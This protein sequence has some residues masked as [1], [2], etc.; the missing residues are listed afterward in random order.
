MESTFKFRPICL[1][2]VRI[3]SHLLQIGAKYGLTLAQI[4][5]ILCRPDEDE[6]Q[7]SLLERIVKKARLITDMMMKMQT[8]VKDSNLRNINDDSK[9]NKTYRNMDLSADEEENGDESLSGA[10]NSRSKRNRLNS[11]NES[12]FTS[13][14]GRTT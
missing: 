6:T 4:G 8:K 14:L 9:K 7:L 11:I 2:N 13:N 1:R 3:S 5:Q 10:G 12:T